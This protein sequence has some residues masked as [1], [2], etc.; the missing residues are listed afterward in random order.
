[1]R[2]LSFR[3]PK[4]PISGAPSTSAART[5]RCARPGRVRDPPDRPVEAG[6]PRALLDVA[7]VDDQRRRRGGAPRRRAGSPGAASP[8]AAGCGCR[9]RRRRAAGRRGRGRAPSRRGSRRAS[10]RASVI[11]A[12]R[13]WSTNSCRTTTPGRLAQRLDDPAV[14]LGIVADVV[15]RDVGRRRAPKAA[16]AAR[17]RPRCASKAPAGA[18]RCSPRSPTAREAAGVVGDLHASSRSIARSHVTCSAT[19]LPAC[20]QVRASSLVLAEPRARLRDGRAARGSQTSPV[21]RSTHDLE[22]PARVGRRDDGLLGQERLEGHHPEVLVDGRVVDGEAAGVEIGELVVAHAAAKVTR[23]SRPFRR[24]RS[25]SRSR[26]GPSPATTP[27]SVALCGQR[28][29]HQV[30]ALRAVEPADGEDEVAVR[31]AAVGERAAAGGAAPRRRCPSTARAGRRRSARSRTRLPRLAEA[32]RVE[33][34]HLAAERAVVRRTR[35][36]GRA[37]C[38]RARTPGGTGGAARRPCSGGARSTRG[39]SSRRRGRSRRPSA[40][41]RS[42]SR[43]RN[44]CVS[45]RSPGYHLN[46]IVTSRPRGRARAAAATSSSAKISAPPRANGTC[47]RQTAISHRAARRSRSRAARRAASFSRATFAGDQ[48]GRRASRSRSS[49]SFAG[50]ASRPRGSPPAPRAARASRERAAARA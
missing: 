49:G 35:R 25:S 30:D 44:A 4:Q 36:T 29:E 5:S 47:G 39:T 9:A 23:P 8:R 42:A 11:P 45:T 17:P 12:T 32:T 31:V 28:L 26:S 24:A 15:E 50:S 21:L 7:R 2:L 48:S 16:P 43:Q 27:R 37:P 46:G 3:C 6:V 13:W 20:P 38:G 22:R 41:V 19:T 33:P 10:P 14:R 34:L 18:A 1:M 40:S